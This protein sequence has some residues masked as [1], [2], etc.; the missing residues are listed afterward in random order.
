MVLVMENK[1]LMKKLN[2]SRFSVAIV[3]LGIFLIMLFCNFRTNLVADDYRYCF[4]F[5]DGSR[6]D[7][8]SDIIPSMAAHR[9]SMN[10]RVIAHGLVQLFLMLPLPVFKV[11]NA[12]VFTALIYLIYRFSIASHSH[13]ALLLAALFGAVWVLQPEFGQVFLWLDGSVNYLWCGVLFLLWL[14]P[15]VRSFRSGL[16]MSIGAAAAYSLFSFL[17]G[18]YSENSTVALV[19]MALLFM[20]VQKLYQKKSVPLWQIISLLFMLVGFCLMIFTPGEIGNKS[21][22]GFS[23]LLANFWETLLFYL[24]FWPLLILYALFYYLSVKAALSKDARILSLLFLGGSLAG[25]FVLTFALYCAGRS[26]YIALILLLVACGLLFAE[27][28]EEKYALMLS[29]VCAICL[30]TTGYKLYVG[31]VDIMQTNYKLSFNE[32]LITQAAANGEKDVQL[33]R[34][35]AETK[36]SAVEGLPYLNTEDSS[37]WPNV[38]MAKYYGVDTVIGY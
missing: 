6:I 14:I 33:P 36:Y 38:Y 29:V 15:W 34:F 30:C 19:F 11:L 31:M 21:A 4:S 10:G 27:L 25:H 16:K 8:L 22:A 2:S 26:T 17:V 35:Y 13:N 9:V 1:N 18:A 37:D 12:L 20:G 24:R 32:Q 5:Y 28:N 3:L 7:S 23:A